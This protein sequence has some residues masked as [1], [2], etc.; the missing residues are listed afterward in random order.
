VS[1][2]GSDDMDLFVALQKLDADGNKVNPRTR[3]NVDV[4]A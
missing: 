3:V 2:E 4:R 1:A